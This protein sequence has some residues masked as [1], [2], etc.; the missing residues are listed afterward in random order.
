M[1]DLF[2]GIKKGIKYFGSNTQL[3]INSL[4]LTL[5]YFIGVGLSSLIAKLFRKHFL[6]KEISKN[7]KSYWSALNLNKEHAERYYRQF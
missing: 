6:D 5:V 7:C 4:L 2:I 3:L 1:K